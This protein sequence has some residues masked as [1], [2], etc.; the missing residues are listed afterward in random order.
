MKQFIR[1][2]SVLLVL[3][4]TVTVMVACKDD[5][6]KKDD[7]KESERETETEREAE[8]E[9]ELSREELDQLKADMSESI[10]EALDKVEG[11]TT[12]SDSEEETT[13]Y[14]GIVEGILGSL[15]G[16]GNGDYDYSQIIGEVLDQYIG[17]SS[18]S[19]FIKG[20]IKSWLKDKFGA[21]VPD[22]GSGEQSTEEQTTEE[23]TTEEQLPENDADAL[24]EYIAQKTAEAISD[25][26][27]ER[28][29]EVANG[30]LRDS[31]YESVYNA[32]KGN[33]G[34]MNGILEEKIPG[35]GELSG[36]LGGFTQ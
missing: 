36:L 26:I 17:S 25:A 27:V 15:G 29:N 32:M 19:S 24:R 28:I 5:G 10:L 31:I 1:L 6:N 22:N 14:A 12:E 2:I 33:E 11:E 18:T 7:P 20:L 23:Q 9:H 30:T 13:E 16:L 4:M 8:T 21:F 35:Y 34:F 3:L